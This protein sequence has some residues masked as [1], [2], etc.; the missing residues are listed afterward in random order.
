VFDVYIG[1]PDGIHRL[2]ESI[3][4]PL[5]LHGER[6]MAEYASPHLVVAGTYGNGLYRRADGGAGWARVGAGLTASAFRWLGPATSSAR[7]KDT[8]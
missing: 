6:V 4:K 8:A 1:T 7:A 3:V 2:R 5:G